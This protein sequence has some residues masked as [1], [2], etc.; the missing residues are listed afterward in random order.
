M[1]TNDVPGAN[2]ANAD[3]LSMGCWAEHEDGS[4]ILVQNTEGDRVV[5]SVFDVG[6]S[7]ALEWRDAMPRVGFN[8]QF[9]WPND[10]N[11]KWTWHDKTEFPWDLVFASFKSG[12]VTGGNADVIVSA[13][14]RI[15]DRLGMDSPVEV[16]RD[17]EVVEDGSGAKR[18]VLKALGKLQKAI[19]RLPI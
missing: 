2:A 15:A 13:A 12:P 16:D 7:P 9:S 4:L 10:T 6:R 5:Y 14:Q 8:K 17:V 1:S 19:E 3:Q 11:T 18:K